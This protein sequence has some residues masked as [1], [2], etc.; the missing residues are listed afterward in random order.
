MFGAGLARPLDGAPA[1]LIDAINRRDLDCVG[2]D[3][4]SGDRMATPARI[5]GAAPRCRL[6][7]TFFRAKPGHLLLPG[8]SLC[9]ELIVADIGIPE[10]VLDDIRPRTFVNHPDLWPGALPRPAVDGN[11]Y[12]RGHALVLGGA[13]MTGAARLAAEAARRIGAGLVTIAAPSVARVL[14]AAGKPGTIV[15]AAD[16]AAGF[17]GADRRSRATTP[18]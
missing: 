11:K 14:Y 12:G 6:T 13:V 15:A 4:P 7:V 9:G 2:V 8:R 17:R 5:L 1:R 10:R 3:V 16:T 18:R